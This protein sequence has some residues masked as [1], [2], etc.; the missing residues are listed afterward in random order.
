MVIREKCWDTQTEHYSV[1]RINLHTYPELTVKQIQGIGQMLQYQE[2]DRF[3][4]CTTSWLKIELHVMGWQSLKSRNN[5]Y[6]YYGFYWADTRHIV[7]IPLKLQ[8]N[9]LKV[10]GAVFEIKKEIG[11]WKA[12][13]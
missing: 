10:N 12:E 6:P 11:I 2:A 7:L 9:I 4:Y 8:V 1:I 13:L 5:S 3:K